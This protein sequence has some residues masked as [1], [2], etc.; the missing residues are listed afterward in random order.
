M[1][2]RIAIEGAPPTHDAGRA[3]V[4]RALPVGRAVRL[5]D[6]SA[7][8]SRCRCASGPTS[9]T[10]AIDAI[11]R[12]KL[13][14][15]RARGLREPPAVRD[16]GRHEEARR[17]RARAGARPAASLP[18]RAVGGPRPGELGRARSAASC[19]LSDSLGMTTV[20]VTHE[21]Q[22]IFAI[23][24]H[25]IMLDRGRARHHRARAIR[26]SCATA[27]TDPRVARFLQ[28]SRRRGVAVATRRPT[29]GSSACSS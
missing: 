10:R 22:S 13:R 8:T 17:H 3:G 28:P 16:L 29:T 12:A 26:A 2:G 27:S 1:A 11:V 24:K 19:T 18:R 9:T 23:A 5:D 6:A 20:I 25:C 15:R 21:L 14:A 7:R 4:R